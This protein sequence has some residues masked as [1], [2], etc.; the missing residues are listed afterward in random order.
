MAKEKIADEPQTTEDRLAAA[1]EALARIQLGNQDVQR[2]QLKQTAPRSNSATPKI[3]AFNPRGEKDNPMPELKCE[4]NHPYPSRPHLH[5]LTREEVELWN[6]MVPGAYMV[7]LNDGTLQ[8]VL[9]TGAINRATGETMS[10]T[11]GGPIDEDTGQ[12]T[13]L[14]TDENKQRFPSIAT[15]TRQMLGDRNAF[16]D[17]DFSDKY[18]RDDSPALDVMPMKEEIRKV[19]QFLKAKTDDEREDAIKAGAL[20]IS[21]GE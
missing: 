20:S 17:D 14:F 11:M 10:M 16:N 7:E 6:L 8:P 4:I 18:G 3:S 21:L 12:P 19:R 9:V 1:L 5:G 13:P 15:Y 2:K